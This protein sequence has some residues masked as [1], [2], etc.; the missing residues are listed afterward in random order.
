[1]MKTTIK[2]M[3]GQVLCDEFPVDG[4]D[5]IS[6]HKW[7]DVQQYKEQQEP[8]VQVHLNEFDRTPKSG[9]ILEVYYEDRITGQFS[10]YLYNADLV[11]IVPWCR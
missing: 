6:V 9:R 7:F 10:S 1:M 11:T 2:I 4:I 5:H 8:N 3:R